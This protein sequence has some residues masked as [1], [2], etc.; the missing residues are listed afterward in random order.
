MYL[1]LYSVNTDFS[2]MVMV[3]VG[4]H[5]SFIT[6]QSDVLSPVSGWIALW[7]VSIL[8]LIS[9]FQRLFGMLPVFEEISRG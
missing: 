5:F 7:F 4:D 6:L 8:F 3:I 1:A 9:K 2:M